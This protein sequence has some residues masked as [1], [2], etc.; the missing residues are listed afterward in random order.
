LRAKHRGKR[1]AIADKIRKTIF[2]IFGESNLPKITTKASADQIKSWKES[3]KIKEAYKKLN[4]N[5]GDE[6][7]TWCAR[8]IRRSWTKFPSSEQA[9][10]TISV[11][12][13]IFNPNIY[14]IRIN[15]K[16]IRNYMK[17]VLV[18]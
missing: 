6:D 5:I 13:Y 1:G 18:N 8:I 11:I 4:E 10:F 14:S 12:K 3:P 16:D 7:E 15:D 17:K 2:E 9:A